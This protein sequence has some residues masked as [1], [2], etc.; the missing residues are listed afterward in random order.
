MEQ[1]LARHG[2]DRRTFIKGLGYTGVGLVFATLGG[3][4]SLCRRIRNRPVRRR[5]RT[6]SPEVDAAIATYRN[7]VGLMKALPA[8]DPRSWSAQATIHGTPNGFNFCQ[9]GTVHFFSWHR[10]YLL[11]LEQI[12]QELTGDESFGLPY[13]NWNQDPQMHAAFTD[14][15]S[16]LF[17][18]RFNTDLSA[19]F[20]PFSDNTLNG[21]FPDTNFFTF[22]SQI[23]GT[24]HNS[25]HGIIGGEMGGATSA[26][27]PIFWMHHCMVDYCWAKWN[28]ELGNDNTNDPAWNNTS[29]DHFVDGN[30]A[31][32]SVTAGATPLMPLLSYRYESSAIGSAA[33]TPERSASEL[34]AIERR[35]REGADVRFEIRKQIR[36][37]ERAQLRMAKPFSSKLKVAAA[38]LSALIE[39]D[40]A[41]ERIFVRVDYASLPPSD[42]FFVRVFLNLPSANAQTPTDDPHYV[43]SFAFF[44]TPDGHEG[45]GEAHQPKTD[46]LVH[47][48]DALRRLRQRGEL[49]PDAPLTVQLVAVPFAEKLAKPEAELRLDG[50]DLIVTPVHIRAR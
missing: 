18:P 44:G 48:T 32:V 28:L 29:W 36:I 30:G 7:A 23:E 14:A 3:C 33:A 4:E 19:F 26:R 41:Q 21:I 13:W 6:G 50:V 2:L 45:H 49:R 22:S 46:F 39:S 5:L 9:H 42:D 37:A 38:D 43:G 47:A 15:S 24:P 10:A 40:A 1:L 17:H 16:T 27:D 11:Y 35:V 20:D 34:R 31:P 25:A 12:C 8:S